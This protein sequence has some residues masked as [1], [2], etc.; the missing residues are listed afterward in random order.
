MHRALVCL[1]LLLVWLAPTPADADQPAKLRV[2]TLAPKNSA[3]GKVFRVWQKAVTQKSAGK[4]ELQVFYNASMGNEETMVSKMKTGGLDGAALSS[5][6]LSRI[7]KNVLVMQLPGVVDSW[8]LLDKVRRDLGPELERR[9]QTH[10]FI[11]AGWGDLG[12][13]RQMSRGFAARRPGDLKGHHPLVWRNEPMGAAIYASIGGIVPVPLSPTEVLPAL[14]SGKI[15][16]LSAPSLAAEQ[17]QWTPYLDHISSNPTVCAVGG[18]VFRKNAL[19]SLPKDLAEV[20]W[21]LQRR[22]GDA[23]KDRVR[24]LDEQA[25]K[26]LAKKMTVIDLSAADRSE[27]RK[28]LVP[29]I[30]QLGQST[31]DKA[32]VDKVIALSGKA[33]T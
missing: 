14:R 16:V 7:D 24:K 29:A 12:L 11:I 23:T 30:Q 6:G 18:T 3:W 9:F 10:G 28:V 13:V 33:K 1:L 26:R 32:L 25:Y 5:V 27:W 2:A 22:S 21:E 17:L 4:L 31:F 8:S 15:D 20:F 19:D